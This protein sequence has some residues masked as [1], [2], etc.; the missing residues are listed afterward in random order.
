[1]MLPART[2]SVMNCD[3]PP[4][5][6]SD[7]SSVLTKDE[8]FV[9]NIASE[10]S[11]GDQCCM[12]TEEAN[13]KNSRC[14][15]LCESQ[16][17]NPVSSEPCFNDDPLCGKKASTTTSLGCG[18]ASVPSDELALGMSQVGVPHCLYSDC[19]RLV[20]AEAHKIYCSGGRLC[21]CCCQMAHNEYDWLDQFEDE[22]L[23]GCLFGNEEC[24]GTKV[25][26]LNGSHAGMTIARGTTH[27]DTVD[28][29]DGIDLHCDCKLSNSHPS[30]DLP[31]GPCGCT[32]S[33]CSTCSDKTSIDQFQ[34]C[35]NVRAESENRD[36]NR[37]EVSKENIRTEQE[38]DPTLELILQWK[39]IGVKPDWPTVAPYGKELKVYWHKWDL[40]EINDEILCKK[41]VRD[42]GTGD[43][44]LYVIPSS[45][46]KTLFQH[47]HMYITAGHL[48]RSKTYEKLRQRFYWCNMHR[49]VSYW[50]RICPT[51]GSRK[52]PPRQAK[53][54]MQQYNVGCPMERIALDLSGPYP[55]SKR[56]NKY[57][58][59]ISCYF[60]KWLE[61]IPLKNQ[62][63]TTVAEALVN[64]FI[65]VHGVPLQIHADR[66]SNFEARVFQEG[67]KLLGI[68]KTRTT[69][70]RPQSDGMVERAN[71]TIQNMIASYVSD[72][73][74]DWDEHIPLLLLA[75]R[76]SVHETTGVSPARM[77][78]GRDLTLPVD[79]ALGR[80]V[81]EEKYCNTDYA[82]E[83]KQRL[84][85]I[86]E[87]ARKHLKIASDSMKRQYDVKAKRIKYT[88]G[89]AVWYFKPKR[90][91][92]FNPKIQI[93]WKGP[94]II[95]EQL[96]D[97]LYRIQAGPKNKSEIVHHDSIRLYLC[98]DK[99]TWFA[100]KIN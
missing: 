23:L 97:V 74:T 9:R 32:N 72:N 34:N 80:P 68:D 50:C 87:Y 46:R 30:G 3:I 4:T 59:V 85:A 22:P 24:E 69:V 21:I 27:E 86:H 39:R 75:Y 43:D 11:V 77:V 90:R 57:L 44:Y 26:S 5:Y 1:M 62:E 92:G 66:G 35:S 8:M 2:V 33:C 96:N 93:H 71:R 38:K 99:P 17:N 29:P 100:P 95:T 36:R 63:T 73:Q 81:R 31:T 56:G 19:C 25:C 61:A 37:V 42:D 48:G 13:E 67:C 53:A 70:R 47:L 51:C 10:A 18:A 15:T 52:Q 65:S 89:D 6:D 7:Q 40:I 94:Y 78:F 54:P 91:K 83:L 14:A 64:Q 41:H 98:E 84:L 12:R 76:S 60:S 55:V 49:D 79:L 58:L 45:L 16:E 82:Y 88:A 28:H 20:D